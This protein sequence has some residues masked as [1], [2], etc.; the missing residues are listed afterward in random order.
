VIKNESRI[1]G[2]RQTTSSQFP[3]MTATGLSVRLIKLIGPSLAHI[4]SA[5]VQSMEEL[6]KKNVDIGLIVADL[7]MAL[8]EDKVL[9]LVRDL[10]KNTTVVH[11]GALVEL[12]NDVTINM[13]YT[14]DLGSLMDTVRFAI[15]LNF[16]NFINGVSA[17]KDA[18]H[19]TEKV[20]DSNST[21]M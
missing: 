16:A 1:I 21:T 11:N 4:L 10:L 12:G 9:S 20:S 19:Q 14:G 7:L 15:Q 6:M 18:V 17:L 3:A 13:V 5:D 2:G 8:D